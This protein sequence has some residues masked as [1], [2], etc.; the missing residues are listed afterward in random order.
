MFLTSTLLFL[1]FTKSV[2]IY[3][4]QAKQ[5]RENEQNMYSELSEREG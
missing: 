1:F 4:E 5:E 2:I 3:G